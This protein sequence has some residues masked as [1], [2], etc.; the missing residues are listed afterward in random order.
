MGGH[1]EKPKGFAITSP[2]G[3]LF[4]TVTVPGRKGAD[5]LFE[6]EDRAATPSKA[7]LFGDV[8]VDKLIEASTW[9]PT[10]MEVATKHRFMHFDLEF[11]DV[12]RERGGF[13]LVIGNPPWLKPRWT[14]SQVLSEKEPALGIRDLSADAV[15]RLK[16]VIF[17]SNEA[18]PG[19]Y[20]ENY[21][22]VGGLQSFLSTSSTYPFVGSGQPNLY[23]CFVDLAFRITSVNGCAA[24]IHQDNHLL[25]PNGG[26]FRRTWYQR[27]KRHFNFINVMTAQMFADVGHYERFSL[28]VYAGTE[29][30][31]GFD[32]AGTLML[33]SMI[34]ESYQHDG[35]GT[36]PGIKKP[37]GGWDTRGHRNRIVR[38]DRS[39]LQSFA[40]VIE[41]EGTS[42]DATRF[43]FPFSTQT[44]AIFKAFAAGRTSFSEGAKPFQMRR[45]W[46]ESTATKR[47]HIIEG[48]VGF[49]CSADEVILTG[50]LFYVGNPFYKC[51]DQNGNKEREIDLSI[52]DENYMQRNYYTRATEKSSYL[53]GIT[54]LVWDRSKR[55][56]DIYRIAF[57]RMLNLNMERTL[58]GALIPPGF[59]HVNTIESLGF[60]AEERLVSA[61]PLWISL[62]FDFL[63]KATGLAD[64]R[65]SS[66]RFF[67]W[68]DVADTAKHRALRLSCLTRDYAG[69]WD[70]CADKL[71]FA[72]WSSAD[73]RLK[74][75]VDNDDARLKTWS[76]S[77][78]F[79]SDFARRLAL[80]EI[81]VLVAQALGLTLDQ[82]IEMYRTQFHVLDENERG[83]WYDMNGRIAWTCSK[84]LTGVGLLKADGK[85]P[86]GREWLRDYADAE[87]GKTFEC[88]VNIDFLPSGP[89]KAKRTY[90]APFVTCDREADYRRAWAFFEAHANKKAA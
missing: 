10:A 16:P 68:A 23:K 59:A 6:L 24:L 54:P 43:L 5:T 90:L 66:L 25:D 4:E 35:V 74:V 14:D 58:I 26:E 34:D 79:R 12:M 73:P 44:L 22:A 36:L 50:P 38:I 84:G 75:E 42:F 80:V 71:D 82:L 39:A 78:G 63:V 41:D 85:K 48:K 19:W 9:L 51:P 2:Q 7:D 57:R 56:T 1:V 69:L 20:L 46:D 89:Q 37:D 83:T 32:H 88:E 72:D 67:P 21:V 33:P 8:D 47:D 15:D 64:L 62:P 76:S 53:G 60:E 52:I 61:Y 86:T 13:D 27:I 17:K 49:P 81:D 31:I 70:R 29:S 11:A 87:A 3:Q 40:A 77:T 18:T 55:H 30:E 28:N 45:L 65:E